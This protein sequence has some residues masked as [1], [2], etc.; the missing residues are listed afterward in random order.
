[1]ATEEQ[2]TWTARVLGYSSTPKAPGARLSPDEL[3]IIFRDAKEEVDPSISKLQS[4]MRATGD[5]DLIRIAD[6][7]MFGMTSGQGV[8]LMTALI[9]YRAA[10]PEKR[11]AAMKAVRDAAVAY[12]TA[13]WGHKLVD[14]VDENKLGVTVGIKSKL[15]PALDTIASAA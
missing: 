5:V 2:N 14:L 11:D 8:G 4:E 6:Y 13:V 15:G 3:L 10:P 12:K 9:D 1:M 7:G